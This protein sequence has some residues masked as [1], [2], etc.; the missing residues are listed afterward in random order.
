MFY[1]WIKFYI[2]VTQIYFCAIITLKTI[3]HNILILYL[4]LDLN[5]AF[6]KVTCQY[7]YVFKYVFL[8]Q[9]LLFKNYT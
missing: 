6:R 2:H 8:M 4:Y 3:A 1:V 5:E 7:L 9:K